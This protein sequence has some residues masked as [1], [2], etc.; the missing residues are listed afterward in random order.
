MMPAGFLRY[1]TLMQTCAYLNS[2]IYGQTQVQPLSY[3]SLSKS[4]AGIERHE[5][6]A[7]DDSLD[8]LDKREHE[9]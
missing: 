3:N 5:D 4:S 1:N 2:S 7:F 9:C 8:E 6:Y